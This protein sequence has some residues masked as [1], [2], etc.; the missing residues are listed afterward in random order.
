VSPDRVIGTNGDGGGPWAGKAQ[1][2]VYFNQGG[3]KY[4]CFF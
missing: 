4:G 3:S 1:Q 2:Q